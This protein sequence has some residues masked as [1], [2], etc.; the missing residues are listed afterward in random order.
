MLAETKNWTHF[1]NSLT[2][3]EK[4]SHAILLISSYANFLDDKIKEFLDIFENQYDIFEYDI[5]NK[6]LSK[7]AFVEEINKLYFSS[8]SNHQSK[9]FILKNIEGAHVSLLNSILK[10][11]EDPPR[12]TYFLLTS[13]S[14]NLVIPTVVSRCQVFR[15]SKLDNEK[16]LKKKLDNWKKSPYNSIFSRIFTNFEV[17]INAIQVVSEEDLVKFESLL[18]NLVKNKVD[19]LIFLNKTLTKENTIIYVKMLIFHL[20]SIFFDYFKKNLK[21]F[22]KEKFLPLNFEKMTNIMQSSHNFLSTLSTNENFNVQKSAFLV[23]LN[24][25]LS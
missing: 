23:R 17:A 16:E 21:N 8:F 24:I 1:L 5:L 9:I 4:I 18:R 3:S 12:S 15:F 10:I 2:E 7:Q 19:F 14:Q 20:K 22:K 6:T 25:I 13:K 11:L